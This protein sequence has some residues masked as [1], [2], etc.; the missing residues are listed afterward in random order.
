MEPRTLDPMAATAY[1]VHQEA[2]P[3]RAF[4][5]G[6]YEVRFARSPEEL[7][8]LLR[9]RYAVFNVELG[10]G[11]EGSSLTGRDEDPLDRRFHH[12]AIHDR[13][14]GEPIGT[15]RMQTAEMAGGPGGFYSACIFD[16]TGMAPEVLTESVEVGRACIAREHRN[17]KVLRLLWR[18]LADY[19]LWNRK[20]YLFG[21]CSLTSQDPALG[22]ATLAHLR[23]L[24]HVRDD[25]NVVPLPAAACGA[26]EFET[27]PVPH[28]PALFQSYLN[29][30]A[31][32]CGP[33]A[34]DREFRT[35]DFLVLLDVQQLD[36]RTFRSFFG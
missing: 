21:C 35:I 29:L 3:T 32:V 11:L 18:G 15:Y 25:R 36:P 34:I 1:P 20:R 19:M 28:V 31:E 17:G 24:G 10:E 2:L 6:R 9:L 5:S 27:L 22:V 26:G 8:G 16:L 4:A 14:S 30:G 7:D 23:R 13:D 12:L 33:P